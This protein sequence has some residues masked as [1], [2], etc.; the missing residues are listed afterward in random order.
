MISQNGGMSMGKACVAFQ[1][2]SVIEAQR[3]LFRGS[4]IVMRYGDRFEGNWL[5][6]WDQGERILYQCQTCGGYYLM[7]SSEFYGQEDSCSCDYFPVKGPEEAE[8]LN[9]RW[10]GWQIERSFPERYLVQDW[11][12][13]PQWKQPSQCEA[14]QH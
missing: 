4:R 10:D 6:A 5:H 13:I 1:M 11:D 14:S 9:R 8:S 2:D 3:H 12:G 7:Q